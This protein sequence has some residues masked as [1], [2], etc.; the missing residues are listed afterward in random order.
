VVVVAYSL[1]VIFAM[2]AILSALVCGSVSL[3][4]LGSDDS[5]SHKLAVGMEV[6]FLRK[7]LSG[8]KNGGV[9]GSTGTPGHMLIYKQIKT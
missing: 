3:L 7:A 9:N 4:V 6:P 1:S 8:S 5:A 2:S